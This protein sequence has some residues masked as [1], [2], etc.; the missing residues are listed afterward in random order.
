MKN[1]CKYV[2]SYTYISILT[3]CLK[4]VGDLESTRFF[5][6]LQM[7][8]MVRHRTF[9]AFP[10]INFL[11]LMPWNFM[12][13]ESVIRDRKKTLKLESVVSNCLPRYKV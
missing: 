13:A 10:I 7:Y 6:F 3:L 8:I 5:F 9:R 11:G 4:D 12:A 1:Y 2:C